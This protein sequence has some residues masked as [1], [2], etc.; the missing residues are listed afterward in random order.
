MTPIRWG[1][2]ATGRIAASFASDLALI[3]D[4]TLVA[5]GSRTLDAASA[6]AARFG[7]PEAY[8]SWAELAAS[9]VDVIYVAT[10]HSSHHEA[11]LV[12]LSAGKAV[13]CEKPFT[14]DV[15][16]SLDLMTTAR[17]RGLFLMEA[18]WM[19]CN[20]TVLHAQQ[21]VA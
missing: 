6:F 5:V 18:M 13:L 8:G 14:L 21:L 19:R 11:T 16:T 10:P 15:A 12:C 3:P 4:A 20:P 1:I 17:S 2:L 7:A 9:D